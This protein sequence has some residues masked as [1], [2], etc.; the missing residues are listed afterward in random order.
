MKKM[1]KLLAVLLTV[2]VTAVMLCAC[3]SSASKEEPAQEQEQEQEPAQEAVQEE[4]ASEGAETAEA[5]D[6]KNQDKKIVYISRNLNDMYAAF[7][8]KIFESKI[9]SDYPGWT[10]ETLDLQEDFAKNPDYIENAVTMGA[11]GIIGQ[12]MTVN[13]VDAARK[14]GEES[15]VEVVAFDALYPESVGSLAMVNADNYRMGHM[16]GELAAEKLPENAKVCILSIARKMDVVVQ[17]DDGITDALAELRP[18]VEILTIGDV[19][20]DK[21]VGIQITTDW[22]TQYGQ[23]DGILGDSDTCALAAIE[24]YRA[25]GLDLSKTVF[26]GLDG[27][28]DACNAIKNGELTG[29]VLQSAE[30]YADLTLQICADAFEGKIDPADGENQPSLTIDPVM[31][32]ADNVDEYIEL[33]TQYGLMK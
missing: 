1:K 31:I 18:D 26:I 4:T 2:T 30:Q 6:V 10:M 22:I 24:A 5:V 20:F 32:T 19:D 25:A 28:S 8:V 33:Y 12:L 15:G 11:D 9:A 13:P 21:N 23:L 17:R 3:G 29:S 14:V 27:G 16:I 7:L